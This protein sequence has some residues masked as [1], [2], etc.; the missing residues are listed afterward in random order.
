[1]PP[2]LVNRLLTVLVVEVVQGHALYLHPLFFAGL[3]WQLLYIPEVFRLC[4]ISSL[5]CPV[6]NGH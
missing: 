5:A 4:P 6:S 3:K 2:M 1:M